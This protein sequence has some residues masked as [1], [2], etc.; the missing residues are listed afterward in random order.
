ML[1]LPIRINHVWDHLRDGACPQ[2]HSFRSRSFTGFRK[3]TPLQPR[4]LG[5]R[6]VIAGLAIKKSQEEHV[7]YGTATHPSRFG[8]DARRKPQNP[9]LPLMVSVGY[10]KNGLDTLLGVASGRRCLRSKLPGPTSSSRAD[11]RQALYSN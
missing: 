7:A 2:W 1:K 11:V 8:R 10:P 3:W 4:E 6:V 5:P 9:A